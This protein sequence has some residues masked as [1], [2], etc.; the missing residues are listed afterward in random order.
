[1][2]FG[3]IFSDALKYPISDYQKLLILGVLY[4]IINIPTIIAQFGFKNNALSLIF[5]VVSIFLNLIIF[6]FTLSVIRNAIDLDDAIPDFEWTKNLV[7]GIK[8]F[9]VGFVYY[10]IPTIIVGIVGIASLSSFIASIGQDR[11]AVIANATSPSVVM[12]VIPPEAWTTFGVG[13]AITGL[14]AM[15]LFLIFGLFKTVGLCR[16]AKYETL[17]EAFNFGEVINDIKE[18]GVLRLFGFLIVLI[19]IV[20]VLGMVIG[21]V[22]A[23]P[24]IGII[25]G[26]LVGSPFIALFYNRS[27]GLLYSDI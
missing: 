1:M 24:Y 22:S 9:V 17:G 14:V 11:L 25:I 7:D 13:L 15:V 3:E 26:Y 19:I 8:Y 21:I 6:G 10:L 4:V 12:N 16:L 20:A 2:E 23:I 5:I 18:I 27:I